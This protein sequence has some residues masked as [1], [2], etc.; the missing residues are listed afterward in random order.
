VVTQ[1]CRDNPTKSVIK[2]PG[3][4]WSTDIGKSAAKVC[5]DLYINK[6]DA[7]HFNS[8]LGLSHSQRFSVTGTKIISHLLTKLKSTTVKDSGQSCR[9][10]FNDKWEAEA[11]EGHVVEADDDSSISIT[12]Q[13][14]FE[15]R[16]SIKRSL[17]HK[18]MHLYVVN[19]VEQQ[20][21]ARLRN[22][23]ERD[24]AKQMANET[25]QRSR[26]RRGDAVAA[27][28]LNIHENEPKSRPRRSRGKAKKLLAVATSFVPLSDDG[29][30]SRPATD[31]QHAAHKDDVRE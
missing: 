21:V 23:R 9:V 20:A 12:K 6:L 5:G 7:N 25:K 19:Q 26:V 29:P 28:A 18:D 2:T 30:E 31:S 15:A 17:A 16:S 4:S 22:M 1:H 3:V 14:L 11:I 8:S 24:P 27:G 13:K 10:V